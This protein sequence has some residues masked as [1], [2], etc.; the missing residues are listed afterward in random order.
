MRSLCDRF[1]HWERQGVTLCGKPYQLTAGTYTY[2]PGDP[3]IVGD[4]VT[5]ARCLAD[6]QQ[7]QWDRTVVDV[8]L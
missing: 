8:E 2:R 5:C 1:V 3:E 7:R 6:A 4:G